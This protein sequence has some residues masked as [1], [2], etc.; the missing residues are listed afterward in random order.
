MKITATDDV[1]HAAK[2]TLDGSS[3]TVTAG[4]SGSSGEILLVDH[5]GAR[6]L[7]VRTGPSDPQGL[8]TAGS[9]S[10]TLD[11]GPVGGSL[12]WK[13][14]EESI[15]LDA[16]TGVAAIGGKSQVG[17]VVVCGK[18]GGIAAHLSGSDQAGAC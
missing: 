11:D 12:L 16:Q 18:G 10:A 14:P 9:V 15:T 6:K 5:A 4:G 8:H 1:S 3:A 2:V 13:A 17:A 7:L